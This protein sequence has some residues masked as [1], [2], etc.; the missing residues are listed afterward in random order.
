MLYQLKFLKSLLFYLNW[1]F[2]NLLMKEIHLWVLLCIV[3]LGLKMFDSKWIRGFFGGS[4]LKDN[5]QWSSFLRKL[6]STWIQISKEYLTFRCLMSSL[7]AASSLVKKYTC[8]TCWLLHESIQNYKVDDAQMFVL[9]PRFTLTKE[10]Q[11][12]LLLL[13]LSSK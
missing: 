6:N 4:K 9:R 5:G 11:S 10:E 12:K 1:L 3:F 8:E 7:N 2:I 13:G